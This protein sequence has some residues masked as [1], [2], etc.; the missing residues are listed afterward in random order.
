MTPPPPRKVGAFSAIQ[1][2]LSGSLML[3]PGEQLQEC[4]GLF[5]I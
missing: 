2:A 1:M 4:G 3:M 5:E